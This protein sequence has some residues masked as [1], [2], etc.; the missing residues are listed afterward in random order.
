MFERFG[1]CDVN[2]YEVRNRIATESDVEYL[3]SDVLER[4]NRLAARRGPAREISKTERAQWL[5]QRLA[6]G[7]TQVTAST[8][9]R[10]SRSLRPRCHR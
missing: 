10:A 8:R 6:R 9:K 4:V 5:S 7:R 1:L 3:N 2:C